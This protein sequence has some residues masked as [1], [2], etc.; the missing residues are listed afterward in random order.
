VKVVLR[1][2]VD[3]LGDRGQIVNVAPG[4]ARNFL[5]P[6]RLA[7]EA[8]PGNLRSVELQK[9]V[10]AV[11]EKREAEDARGVA[12]HMAGIKVVISKKAGENDTLY[13]SVTTQEIADLL[14]AQ[15]VTVDRR[16]IHLAVPIK[17]LGTFEVP[18][19]IHRQVVAP[20]VVQVVAETA[21]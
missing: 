12:A 3:N 20:I 21:E 7:L 8:T 15:G 2:D 19:K 18:V 4:F 14:K 11:R 17:T 10:W 13:G 1:Q 5:F 16:K 6:K 9:K